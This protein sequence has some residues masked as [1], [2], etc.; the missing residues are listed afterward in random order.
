MVSALPDAQPVGGAQR[1]PSPDPKLSARVTEISAAAAKAGV[2]LPTGASDEAIAKAEAI[3]GVAFPAEVRAFYLA[4]DGGG[5]GDVCA[6]RELLSLDGIVGQ[7]QIW[8]DLLDRGTFK[9]NDDSK[10]DSGVQK[11]W[12]IPEWIPMTYDGS[13]NHHILDMAPGKGGT[14][15]QILC[16]W[17]DDAPRTLQAPDFLTWL[18]NVK[19]GGE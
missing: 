2:P 9:K 18:E 8:K 14:V 7:W 16:F 4:H 1:S 13:G 10:P 12:W 17:H 11:K 5:D 6:G 19:W 15:G 3:L